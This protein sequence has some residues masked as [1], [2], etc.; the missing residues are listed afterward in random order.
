MALV[1]TELQELIRHLRPLMAAVVALAAI[2]VVPVPYPLVEVGGFTG[3]VLGA[4]VFTSAVV[5]SLGVL[6]QVALAL[7]ALSGP[8][9]HAPSHRQTQGTYKWRLFQASFLR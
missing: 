5:G 6:R 2:Q 1:L 8:V 9:Q 3:V 7:S 4:Q